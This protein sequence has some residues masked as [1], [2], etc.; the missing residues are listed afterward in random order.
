MTARLRLSV[1]VTVVAVVAIGCASQDSPKP[2]FT[3]DLTKGNPT[4]TALDATEEVTEAPT[5][6]PLD[7]T[8][9]SQL[10]SELAQ[11]PDGCGFLVPGQ[12]LL[13]FP[14]D[15]FTVAD[16]STATRI[17]VNL[18]QGQFP[19]AAGKTLDVTEWN[20]NDGWS[21]STPILI[22]IPNLDFAATEFPTQGEMLKSTTSE[23]ASVIVD[24]DTG[25]LVPH[26]AEV[27]AHATDPARQALILRPATSLIETH[28]F[29][30]AL[31]NLVGTNGAPLSP[32]V[33]YQALR[34][35]LTTTEPRVE[36]LRTAYNQ[37][38]SQMATAGVG[39]QGLYTTWYFTVAS[40][41]SLAGRLL[42]MR[43]DAFGQLNGAAPTYAITETSTSDLEP[44]INK[45]LRGTYEVPLYLTNGGAPGSRM[46]FDPDNGQPQRTG[47]Y[48][49]PFTCVVPQSAID[50]GE[51]FPVVYGHGLLGSGDEVTDSDV[52]TTAAT[53]NGVYCATDWIGLAEED[54]PFAAQTLVRPVELPQRGGPPPAGSPQRRVPR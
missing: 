33:G 18:P 2:S 11:T 34:D 47:T 36:N 32:T 40:P 31:R 25:Q 5:A 1:L 3:G 30:V 9:A 10:R 52:Q 7:P 26:W 22:Q 38:F 41:Q 14:S 12:C 35:N 24:L 16:P 21:P 45:I 4:T 51:A 23:S 13:P 53:I 6:A 46:A 28:R 49:A 20:R 27:D 44:G 29:A 15:S 19:N 8:R 42:S 54:V 50:E 43:D 37:V 39:R 17:R 48:T